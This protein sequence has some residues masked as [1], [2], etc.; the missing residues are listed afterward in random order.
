MQEFESFERMA[1]NVV[2]PQGKWNSGNHVRKK[3]RKVEER[4]A[5]VIWR[6]NFSSFVFDPP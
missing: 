1:W 5:R 6:R 2:K 3:G 4:K